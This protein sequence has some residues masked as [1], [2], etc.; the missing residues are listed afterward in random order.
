[1]TEGNGNEPENEDQENGK[2]PQEEKGGEVMVFTPHI[3]YTTEI[4]F[5]RL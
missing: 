4:H 5:I 3:L 1:M 2:E